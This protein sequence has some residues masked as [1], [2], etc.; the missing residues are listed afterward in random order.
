MGRDIIRCIRSHGILP[1]PEC[2]QLVHDQSTDGI[3]IVGMD[4][5]VYDRTTI[6]E[7]LDMVDRFYA[8]WSDED[9]AALEDARNRAEEK[10][11]D[12]PATQHVQKKPGWVYLLQS[13]FGFKIGQ[14][15]NPE[16]RIKQYPFNVD[17]IHTIKSDDALTVE[18]YLHGR[19][20]DKRIQDEWFDLDDQDVRWL[21]GI[22]R[23]NRKDITGGGM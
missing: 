9:I 3:A 16:A 14:T 8:A 12:A 5:E 18:R 23:L 7:I 20:S 17:V 11:K 2:V 4:G 19:F 22:Q 1:S 15:S 13:A 6:N 21:T 10:G